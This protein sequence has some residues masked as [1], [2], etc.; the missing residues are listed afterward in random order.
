LGLG[1]APGSVL[2]AISR[3]IFRGEEEREI[4]FRATLR[5]RS[6][7]LV[8]EVTDTD[9]LDESVLE[10]TKAR[11]I[12]HPSIIGVYSVGGGN[13]AILAAF[14]ALDRPCEVFVG[15]DLDRDNRELLAQQRISAVLH[16]DLETDMR[17]AC[18]L[19]MQHHG[20]ID[21]MFGMSAL[22]PIQVV[23]PFNL[24]PDPIA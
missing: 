6:D 11:L 18:H 4:G 9:G 3:S 7:R 19:I 5:D 14:D 2:I 12:E 16:H 13:R 20:A 17:R 10:R 1:R 8:V 22:S 23:T 21:G 15:H 24:S